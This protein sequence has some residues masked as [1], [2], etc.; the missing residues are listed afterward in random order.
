MLEKLTGSEFGKV[1]LTT[2]MWD[3][4]DEETGERREAELR[5]VYWKSM[6]RR[7]SSTRRFTLTRNSALEIITP[8]I[9]GS[10][11]RFALLLQK[12]VLD[13]GRKLPQTTAGAGLELEYVAHAKEHQ[14]HL[15]NIQAAL[16]QPIT[17]EELQRWIKE[18]HNIPKPLDFVQEKGTVNT[19][20]TSPIS[21]KRRFQWP[22]RFAWQF[23]LDLKLIISL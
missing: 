18:Y 19:P 21:W 15:A 1:V 23:F 10:G 17:N 13:M 20:P 7:G 6:I 8:F 12:E 16:K 14:M 3:E 9:E 4:I 2:T 5:S 11:E 22:W